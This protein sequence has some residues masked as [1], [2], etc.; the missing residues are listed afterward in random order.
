MQKK[1]DNMVEGNDEKMGRVLQPVEGL[2]KKEVYYRNGAA[3]ILAP[4]NLKALNLLEGPV[5]PYLIDEPLVTIDSIYDLL[6]AEYCGRRLEPDPEETD[7]YP[8][9]HKHAQ[10]SEEYGES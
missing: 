1:S 2:E 8:V 4:E 9:P 6:K 7:W 3:V 5:F 10:G